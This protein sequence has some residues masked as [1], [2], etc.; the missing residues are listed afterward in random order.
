MRIL[1]AKK[2]HLTALGFANYLTQQGHN[3]K[4]STSLATTPQMILETEPELIIL[5]YYLHPSG[6]LHWLDELKVTLSFENHRKVIKTK[7]K[8]RGNTESS[9]CYPL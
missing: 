9:S 7:L 1:I 2:N 3:V 4:I 5:G 6:P 8:I